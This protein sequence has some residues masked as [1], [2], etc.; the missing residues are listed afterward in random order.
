MWDHLNYFAKLLFC[1]DKSN[2]ELSPKYTIRNHFIRASEI[3]A[4]ILA[5]GF[6]NWMKKAESWE[7]NRYSKLTFITHTFCENRKESTINCSQCCQQR[8]TNLCARKRMTARLLHSV[9]RKKTVPTHRHRIARSEYS[10]YRSIPRC[11]MQAKCYYPLCHRRFFTNK[12][13]KKLNRWV[14]LS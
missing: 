14:F 2:W 6:L 11:N 4:R 3:Y 1:N 7:K 8:K 10:T 9:V 5:V 12:Y 13:A